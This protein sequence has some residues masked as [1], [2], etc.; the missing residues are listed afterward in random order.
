MHSSIELK[1]KISRF[2]KDLAEADALKIG[3]QSFV[4]AVRRFLQVQTLSRPLLQEMVDHID[5]FETEGTGKKPT[6]RVAIYYRFVGY[7]EIS[8]L[9]KH[10]HNVKADTRQGVSVEY[11]PQ[12]ATA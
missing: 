11:V 5:V 4:N 1:N 2:R 7:I 12:I 10:S 9:P 6:Q 8:E 3:Q